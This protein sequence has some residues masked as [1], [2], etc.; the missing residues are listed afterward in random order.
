MEIVN[1]TK[2]FFLIIYTY[3][4]VFMMRRIF[5]NYIDKES[6]YGS[7]F[8]MT[9]WDGGPC[10]CA[11]ILHLSGNTDSEIDFFWEKT[12]NNVNRY[13]KKNDDIC[14]FFNPII[15][16]YDKKKLTINDLC[17]EKDL[18][19]NQIIKDESIHK[20]LGCFYVLNRKEKKYLFFMD[21][22]VY[23]LIAAFKFL[24][25]RHAEIISSMI[26]RVPT[27]KYIPIFN[28]LLILFNLLKY[29]KIKNRSL[30]VSKYLTLQ[31][32]CV[33]KEISKNKVENIKMKHDLKSQH[34]CIGIAC[35][36]IFRAT[37]KPINYLNVGILVGL[38]N[39][40]FRNNYTMIIIEVK[41]TELIEMIKGIEK[42]IKKNSSLAISTY[43]IINFTSGNIQKIKDKKCDILFT[44]VYNDNKESEKF[45]NGYQF[46]IDQ[47]QVPFYVSSVSTF[48]R[49][50][51]NFQYTTNDIELQK[52]DSSIIF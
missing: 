50:F 2:L 36:H 25:L 6:L 18:T 8:Y 47:I 23:D 35:S 46:V 29:T 31:N 22:R 5:I 24:K 4:I 13:L 10:Y 20:N 11:G 33:M 37:K 39:E 28:E 9:D 40:R 42:N 44:N 26:E 34:I 1:M 19:F 21:H 7:D 48:N 15:D 3:V 52:L 49:N 45:F 12:K 51:L 14:T 27:Y 43:D 32:N 41:N 38:K 16:N 17:L 30:N